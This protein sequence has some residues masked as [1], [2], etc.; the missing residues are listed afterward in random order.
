[1]TAA[2]APS[3]LSPHVESVIFCHDNKLEPDLSRCQLVDSTVNKFILYL[4]SPITTELSRNQSRASSVISQQS[5]RDYPTDPTN[6]LSGSKNG[7]GSVNSVNSVGKKRKAPVP[8]KRS[9]SMNPNSVVAIPEESPSV[10]LRSNS[11]RRGV[12]SPAPA[13]RTSLETGVRPL[14]DLVSFDIM[15]V[16]TL[17]PKGD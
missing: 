8:P 9:G 3:E 1:M 4:S 2:I 12:V 11:G 16:F 14:S 7:G 5:F 17:P 13:P 10:V 15:I 6:P